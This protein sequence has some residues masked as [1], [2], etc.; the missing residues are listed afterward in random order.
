MSYLKVKDWAKAELD[1]TSAINIDPTHWKSYHRR[2]IAR[3]SL[4]KIRASLKDLQTAKQN[5]LN[6]IYFNH[7]MNQSI[8]KLEN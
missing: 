8:G 3:S 5:K 6:I 1:S 2:S 7:L 4:G